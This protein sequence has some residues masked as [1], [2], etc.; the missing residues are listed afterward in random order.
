MR[1]LRRI[2]FLVLASGMALAQASSGGGQNQNS[3]VSD[4]LKALREAIATQQAQIAQQQKQIETLEK[5]LSD[6]AAP[7]AHVEN[8]ALTT[9]TVPAVTVAQA[10][11]E[12][13]K[14]SPLSV[15][16]GGTDFTPGGFVDF[17]NVFRSVNTGN[18][19]STGFN[20]IPF[21]NTPAGQIRSSAPAASIRA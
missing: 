1:M 12:K 5:A 18:V 7:A 17:S 13:P 6:K 2:S 15:R 8:A 11:V 9:N 21:N 14:E 4:E 19:I 20:A 10:D 3:S 16:I